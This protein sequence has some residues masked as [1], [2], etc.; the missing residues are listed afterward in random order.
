MIKCKSQTI[1]GTVNGKTAIRAS[2]AADTA[3]EVIAIGNDATQVEGT[4]Y[5]YLAPFSTCLTVDGQFL[6]L[7]SDGSWK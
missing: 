5:D 6:Q 1:D 3:A 7:G 4:V 2:L